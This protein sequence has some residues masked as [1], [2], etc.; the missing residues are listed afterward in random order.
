MR[1]VGEVDAVNMTLPILYEDNHLLISVKPPNLPVQADASGDDDM[2]S[3]LKADIKERYAKPGDVY[4]G[5]VHRIDRPVGGVIAFARTSKAAARLSA[6]L[7]EHSMRRSYLAAARGYVGGSGVMRDYLLKDTKTNIVS[8]STKDTSGSREA[9]L[10][11]TRLAAVDAPEPLSLVDVRL[12]TGRSHQIRAQFASRGFPLRADARYGAL[13]PGETVAL[14][15]YALELEHPTKGEAMRFT[16]APPDIFPWNL[17][18][19]PAFDL[20]G[21]PER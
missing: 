13:Q 5:L 9:V 19:S 4:L 21:H 8:I 3:M 7:R 12:E 18:G 20:R 15:G 1:S 17:F 16:A 10:S 2:L 11:F 14:W 6:Q